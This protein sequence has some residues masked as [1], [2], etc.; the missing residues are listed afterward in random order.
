VRRAVHSALPSS[1]DETVTA[2]TST[3]GQAGGL[4]CDPADVL[5]NNAAALVHGEP[6]DLSL[7]RRQR[8]RGRILNITSADADHRTVGGDTHGWASTG[9]GASKAHE[10]RSDLF[11]PLERFV[12]AALALVTA[13][14]SASTGRVTQSS[15]V[16]NDLISS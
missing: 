11:E 14:P 2:G 13:D 16:L 7:K 10:R 8:R 1:L 5:V 12:A 4:C 9:H 3:G 6:S 15:S